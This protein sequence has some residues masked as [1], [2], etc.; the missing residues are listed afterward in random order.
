MFDLDS[1]SPALSYR[2]LL[3]LSLEGLI[4]TLVIVEAKNRSKGTF[5]F[6][7]RIIKKLRM[8]LTITGLKVRKFH[9]GISQSIEC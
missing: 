2:C 9:H 1:L 4:L 8:K 3:S 7:K 6:N 5:R